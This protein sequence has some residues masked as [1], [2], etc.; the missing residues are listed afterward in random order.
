MFP[1]HTEV[2]LGIAVAC[3]WVV[4]YASGHIRGR[5]ELRQEVVR[6]T[7]VPPSRLPDGGVVDGTGAVA[8]TCTHHNETFPDEDSARVHAIEKHGAPRFGPVWKYTYPE[9]RE[10]FDG[11]DG[12]GPAEGEE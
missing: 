6:E 7:G 3:S 4:A 8:F 5:R 10:A 11:A 12:E 1:L 2:A 9:G